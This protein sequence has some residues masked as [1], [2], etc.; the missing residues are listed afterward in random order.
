MNQVT[1][2]LVLHAAPAAALL[3]GG[4]LITSNVFYPI[5]H[6]VARAVSY[7][8]L[9]KSNNILYRWTHYTAAALAVLIAVSP[10][11]P[12]FTPSIVS[13][14]VN[15]YAKIIPGSDFPSLGRSDP[16][17]ALGA[18]AIGFIVAILLTKVLEPQYDEA[19]MH[20]IATSVRSRCA[21]IS[22]VLVAGV[23]VVILAGGGHP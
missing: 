9:A 14:W 20:R 19:W 6:R 11:L 21:A 13:R 7:R 10:V 23:A 18:V 12:R 22:A 15:E 5:T 1:E 2:A 4:M 3:A 17:L 16:W 8:S